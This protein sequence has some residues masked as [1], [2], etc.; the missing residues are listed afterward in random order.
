MD[1]N[2][3]IILRNKK[4]DS[5]TSGRAAL[6]NRVIQA[7][8]CLKA[9]LECLW[10]WMD[11]KL[12]LNRAWFLQNLHLP[13]MNSSFE[14]LQKGTD[15]LDSC[16][17]HAPWYFQMM[18]QAMDDELVWRKLK[19][20]W[21][22]KFQELDLDLKKWLWLCKNSYDLCYILPPNHSHKQV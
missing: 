22:K 5:M 17:K 9:L 15:S 13:W 16:F 2:S 12:R 1:N 3:I 19:K 20:I 21:E 11:E 10:S 4:L 18:N 14:L 7:W 8:Q 6:A